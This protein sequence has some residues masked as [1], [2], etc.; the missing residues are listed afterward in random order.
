MN[1][2]RTRKKNSLLGWH[3]NSRGYFYSHGILLI[4]GEYLILQGARGFALPTRKGQCLQWKRKDE[5]RIL[6]WKTMINGRVWF[7]ATYEDKDYSIVSCNNKQ[8]AA[9]LRNILLKANE[10]SGREPVYG[11]INSI[12]DFEIRWGLGS[13]STL[14]VNIARLFDLNPF[15]LYFAL[16]NGSGYDVACAR[17]G[18]PIIY[19]LEYQSDDYTRKMALRTEP[20]SF[21]VPVYSAVD[22]DP[23]FKD[24]LF[25]AWTGKKQDPSAE[26]ARFH[27]GNPADD[28]YL[29]EISN[30]TE[31]I[32]RTADIS[33]FN[34]LLSEHDRLIS[35][36]LGEKPVNET[37]FKDLGGY[38]K[39]LGT[40][41]GG[42]VMITWEGSIDKLRQKLKP[43][44]IDTIF[45][46][47][48]MIYITDEVDSRF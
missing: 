21:P 30:I 2:L 28:I 35:E 45:S 43:K 33:E 26:T 25:F 24:K 48:D 17:S 18:S 11:S 41:D 8:T 1:Y 31:D 47:D 34:L 4:T 12:L 5:S 32:V 9:F 16:S 22:F 36:L 46:F 20:G 29:K 15:V 13:S 6:N 3:D 39:S 7:Q 14:I 40:W 44:G 37:L 23:P 27:S 38:V 10:L 42:F 19:R